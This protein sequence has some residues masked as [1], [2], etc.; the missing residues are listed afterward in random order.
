[1]TTATPWSCSRTLLTLTLS[2]A[3]LF[4]APKLHAQDCDAALVEMEAALMEVETLADDI[5]DQ[6][7][8]ALELA[9]HNRK[10]RDRCEGAYGELS[11]AARGLRVTVADYERAIAKLEARPSGAFWYGLGFATPIVVG[12]TTAV[13]YFF[14][15]PR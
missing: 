7:N 12:L 8:R 15:V 6:R 13:I 3:L 10:Q 1:M 4:A 14:V 11:A 9:E 5:A 2:T